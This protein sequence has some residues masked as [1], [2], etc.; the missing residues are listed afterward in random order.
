M[1]NPGQ[2]W[3][4]RTYVIRHSAIDTRIRDY[5]RW[6]IRS[7]PLRGTLLDIGCGEG[8]FVNYS[9]QKG[10]NS[11]GIDF[12]KEAIELG[13]KQY[14]L[15]TLFHCSLFKL[16]EEVRISGFDI[17]TFF[18][19]LEHLD[20][21]KEFLAET[22]T[23]LKKGGYVALSVPFRDRW[24]FREF[25]DYPPHHLTRW[26]EKSLRTFIQINGFDI[27]KLKISS[28]LRSYSIF[29]GYLIRRSVYGL[30][31]MGKKGLNTS[32]I[33]E[34]G[35]EIRLLTH[36]LIKRILSFVKPRQIRDILLWPIAVITYP[37]VFPWFKGYNLMLIARI[38]N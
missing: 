14:G 30:F 13:R 16:K 35:K 20:R 1:A 11:S 6:T 36:P 2:D 17:V 27:I 21:P 3:Y 8:V 19:V 10:F 7:L 5:Y 37:F 12:S 22:K 38:K 4:D 23:F 34:S 9:S 18:E 24:P 26:T 31:G 25:N 29:L 32:E 33:I 28:G 15:K